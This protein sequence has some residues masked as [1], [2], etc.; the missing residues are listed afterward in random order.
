MSTPS[1]RM[2]LRAA[3]RI[4][5]QYVLIAQPRTLPLLPVPL[6]EECVRFSTQVRLAREHG[7]H[8]ASTCLQ[9]SLVRHLD[10]LSQ[11]CRDTASVINED[12]RPAPVPDQWMLYAELAALSDEFDHVRIDLRRG[13]LAVTIGP[14]E[15]EGVSLGEFEIRLDWYDLG[16]TQ[17]YRV[18]AQQSHHAES[19]SDTTHPHVQDER[20]CEGDARQAIRQALRAGRLSDFFLIVAQTLRTYN[21]G[22]A[23]VALDDWEGVRCTDCDDSVHSDEINSCERC[24]TSCCGDCVRYCE[25][26]DR[27]Y[28]SECIDRCP[29]CEEP[30]CSSCMTRCE[31]CRELHC[32]GCLTDALCPDCQPESEQD[33][34]A[35]DPLVPETTQIPKESRYADP[36]PAAMAPQPADV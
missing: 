26:C 3:G 2:L 4:H 6:W 18:I 11:Q 12:H 1:R 21:A 22:S 35:H 16:D 23:F 15:L 24:S 25:E 10:L 7:L 19:D 5:D 30:Y 8:A 28:C 36:T 33:S 20:L 34:D 32:E 9:R 31:N 29:G 14:V 17:P 27:S 13:E